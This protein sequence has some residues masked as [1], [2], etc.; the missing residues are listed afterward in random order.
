MTIPGY[1]FYRDRVPG[2]ERT[3]GAGGDTPHQSIRGY[4][5]TFDKRLYYSRRE[6]A[7]I[8]EKTFKAGYGVLPI[9]TVM[10]E[11][12]NDTNQL[13][14]YTPDTCAYTDVS[15]VFLLNDLTAGTTFYTDLNESYKL[16]VLDYI[17][18]YD[19]DG[20][21]ETERISAIDRT[22]YASTNRAL[23]TISACAGT[24]TVAKMACC[25]VKAKTEADTNKCSLA[26]YILETN[27]DTGGGATA[28]GGLGTVLVS[29]AVIYTASCVGMDAQ[30][31]TDLG[32]VTTDGVYYI[33]K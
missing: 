2:L 22:T 1:D 21:Y 28:Q 8:L 11:D 23:V 13:V 20:T 12:F 9:G 25:W 6:I 18:L 3:V 19:T 17:V 24:F 14:P 26:K 32:N 15:R 33:L 29:N 16:E 4:T 7:I 30:A 5:A 10:A 31:I 27:V